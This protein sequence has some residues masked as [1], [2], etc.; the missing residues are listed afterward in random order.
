VTG[1]G[2]KL[3]LQSCPLISIQM[4]WHIHRHTIS[5]QYKKYNKIEKRSPEVGSNL[6]HQPESIHRATESMTKI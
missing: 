5:E 1:R 3:T 4:L 2:T 6:S